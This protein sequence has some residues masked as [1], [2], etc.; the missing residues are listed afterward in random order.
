M[1]KETHSA[2]ASAGSPIAVQLEGPFSATTFLWRGRRGELQCSV[3]VKTTYLLRPGACPVADRPDPIW[4]ADLYWESSP[5][6]SVRVPSDLAPLKHA[7]EVTLVG[8]AYAPDSEPRD[9]L[10]VRLAVGDID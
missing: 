5:L 10:A 6:R 8:H 2:D 3:I 9:H 1:D 4:T 7:P